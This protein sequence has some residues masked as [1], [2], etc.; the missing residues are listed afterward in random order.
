[1]KD[2][3]AEATMLFIHWG[4]EYQL[5][6]NAQQEKIAQSLCDLGVDVIV[7]GHPH[8]VQPVDLLTSTTDPDHKTVCLYS[9]GNAVSNQRLGNI[10]YV[11]TAHTEDG[12][13]FSVTFCKYSDGSVYL[14][15]TDIL[16][17]WVYLDKSGS[18][19]SYT[20]IPLDE[21]RSDQWAE[22]Y[23]LSDNVYES[24]LKS[25]DR[26]M[27]IVGDGLTECQNYLEAEGLMRDW[28]YLYAVNPEAA[29][30]PPIT[31]TEPV[32]EAG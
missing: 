28:E 19:S 30:D 21:T 27:A 9:M 32:E 25:Y 15:S 8:V 7:G 14:L 24:A 16:P 3:G 12:V 20:I 22:L 31:V 13:L 26:T 10:S 23:S 5:T 17:T 29:G 1:M 11:K 18:P 2:E 4:V 6:Q